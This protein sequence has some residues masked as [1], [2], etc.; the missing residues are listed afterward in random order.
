MRQR[1]IS[2]SVLVPVAVGVFLLGQPWLTLAL[3]LLGGVA[4]Y[5]AVQLVRR[6]GLD[7]SAAFAIVVAVAAVAGAGFAL[8]PDGLAVIGIPSVSRQV[9]AALV[10]GF[11][12]LAVGVAAAIALARRD[13]GAGFRL[14]PGNVF[15]AVYVSLL[16]FV[17]AIMAVAPSIAPRAP[18]AN[19]LDPGRAWLLIL[20]LTVW[21]FDSLAYLAGRFH[22]RG[23]FM[24]HIS[25]NKTWSGVVGGTAAAVLVCTLLVWATGQHPLGGFL[26]GLLIAVAA[27]TGDLAESL[28]KRAAG[29]KDSGNLLPGHGGMLDRVDSF[30]FA[31]PAMF[32]ALTWIHL[33]TVTQP[34]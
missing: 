33:L 4:A 17:P 24:N 12:A 2:A 16:A 34:A 5:E 21:S 23:R 13:P 31:A 8:Q 10:M 25:P 26:L 14:W 11:V 1:L 15:V 19:L 6:A 20:V 27:Q 30:L 29:A 32:I 7:A 28:L 18:L 9:A 3:A 22:G